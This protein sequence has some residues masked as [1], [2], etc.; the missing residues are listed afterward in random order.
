MLKKIKFFCSNVVTL[1]KRQSFKDKPTRTLFYILVMFFYLLFRITK[2]YKISI[3]KKNYFYTYKPYTQMG[4]GGRGQFVLREYYD[5]FLAYGTKILPKS[6]NFI[7]VGCSRGFFTLYLLAHND[8]D[9]RGVCID[10]FEY[11]LNDLKEVLKLN[12][13]SNTKIVKGIISDKSEDNIFV[14]N[15]KVPSEASIIKKKTHK[16][17]E[18]FYCKSYTIDQLIYSM[19]LISKV[20]FIK[21]DAEGAELEILQ[22]SKRAL[23]DFK[24]I[25]YLE[26]T[27][28]EK[29]I[30][31]LLQNNNYLI[32][33]F[34]N[35]KMLIAPENL[36]HT[37]ILAIPKNYN[38]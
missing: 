15:T 8:S 28:K 26:A 13:F 19:N 16:S 37:S 10:P 12:N 27:R 20:E 34:L 3:N 30:R 36:L 9:G 24:P 2:T 33:H 29:E 38:Y 5:D 21:I 4:M 1:Y 25:I 31:N 23:K 14:R 6:F 7:D 17:S 18:G 35:K 11:A 32:Y 22:G